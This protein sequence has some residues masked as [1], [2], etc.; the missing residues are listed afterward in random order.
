M[1][2]LLA[3]EREEKNWEKSKENYEDVQNIIINGN[4]LELYSDVERLL[5]ENVNPECI[6]REMVIEPYVPITKDSR[7]SSPTRGKKVKR[8]NDINRN[9]PLGALTGFVTASELRP[10]GSKA[11]NTPKVKG[12]DDFRSSDVEDD[13]VDEEIANGLQIRPDL[14]KK[15]TKGKEKA[16]TK[17]LNN[18][19]KKSIPDRLEDDNDD[20]DIEGGIKPKNGKRKK[21]FPSSSSSENDEDVHKRIQK[22]PRKATVPSPDPS[23]KLPRGRPQSGT[24]TKIKSEPPSSSSKAFS[25]GSAKMPSWLLESSDGESPPPPL[26]K[27]KGSEATKAIFNSPKTAAK[28]IHPPS[29]EETFESLKPKSG[30]LTSTPKSLQIFDITSSSQEHEIDIPS[31]SGAVL[32]AVTPHKTIDISEINSTI[33]L[34]A[35]LASP[36][37]SF[38]IRS[39]PTKRKRAP[40][41]TP[42]SPEVAERGQASKPRRIVRRNHSPTPSSSVMAPPPDPPSVSPVA[43]RQQQK[44]K[45][46]KKKPKRPKLNILDNPMLFDVEAEHSGSGISDGEDEDGS[47]LDMIES[48]SDRRFLEELE[49]SQ[50]SDSYDQFAAYRMGLMTQAPSQGPRFASKPK[51][52]GRFAG[53]RTQVPRSQDDWDRSS[54]QI[55]E[56]EEPDEYHMGSFVVDD[57][58]PILFEGSSDL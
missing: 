49:P 23:S 22:Q 45:K 46:E 55:G 30:P 44:E 28:D 54:S 33:D 19:L 18:Y 31:S 48:D 43:P 40:M 47:I 21:T 13:S 27:K 3:E 5:P 16:P 39:K 8:N 32:N 58:E 15:K 35:T 9:I 4:Q 6:Q 37:I 20:M 51:R 38:A 41:M 29:F 24:G 53:G 17:T 2:V 1:D 36:E 7:K 57:D 10:K 14:K 34:S 52:I 11:K 42:S 56:E 26:P 12:I 50:G 25:S